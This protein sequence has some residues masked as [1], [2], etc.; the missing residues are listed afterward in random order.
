MLWNL[1]L[2][3]LVIVFL[4]VLCLVLHVRV[5]SLSSAVQTMRSDAASQRVAVGEAMADSSSS[6][7]QLHV[8]LASAVARLEDRNAALERDVHALMAARTQLAL[9]QAK[10]EQQ[11]G[12]HA[13]GAAAA[14]N[15]GAG[16]GKQLDS[17]LSERLK[18]LRADVDRLDGRWRELAERVNAAESA[19][20][21]GNSVNKL[22]LPANRADQPPLAG[23]GDGG[24]ALT[25]PD[26]AIWI[27]DKARQSVLSV[28]TRKVYDVSEERN[29]DARLDLLHDVHRELDQIVNQCA[30]GSDGASNND[31]QR[32]VYLN[33]SMTVRPTVVCETG[34][35]AGHAAAALLLG[36][37]KRATYV[38][39]DLM[40]RR[41]SKRASVW[42]KTLFDAATVQVIEGSSGLMAPRFFGAQTDAAAEIECDV[43]HIDGGR[44]QGMPLKDL[45]TFHAHSREGATV[46]MDDVQC[47]ATNAHICREPGAAWKRM[48]SEGK[49]A[50]QACFENAVEGVHF[51]VGQFKHTHA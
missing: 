44:F 36:T 38:G 5:S 10:R 15:S 19:I 37:R 22:L 25:D 17:E 16:S 1:Q 8:D 6:V 23:G 2:K 41:Y 33:I 12:S 32:R 3:S 31:L 24:A 47:D 14:A 50:E 9:Q 46:I 7:R 35:N 29:V 48:V 27:K 45:R 11:H 39:F 21:S 34:F 30:C 18:S 40:S 51:C 43:V 28:L 26:P 13:N 4:F 42:L 20:N 49:I